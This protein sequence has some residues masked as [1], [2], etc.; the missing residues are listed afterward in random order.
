MV[1]AKRS[2]GSPASGL[3]LPRLPRKAIAIARGRR[4]DSG[5]ISRWSGRKCQKNCTA[6]QSN[7]LGVLEGALEGWPTG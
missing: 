7:C 1:Q 3:S 2:A 4:S 5:C 6:A